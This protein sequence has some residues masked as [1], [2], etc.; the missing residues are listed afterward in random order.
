MSQQRS[1][2]FE[3]NGEGR[4]HDARVGNDKN[5]A[6]ATFAPE[7]ES[8]WCLGCL[9]IAMMPPGRTGLTPFANSWC[10]I[11]LLVA[12]SCFLLVL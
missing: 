8:V 10:L 4:R 12:G 7:H 1:L 6:S 3:M 9:D 5:A 11:R 2:K